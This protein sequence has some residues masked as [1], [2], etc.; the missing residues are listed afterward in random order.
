MADGSADRRFMQAALAL[1]RRGLGNVWPNPAVGC[2][3]VKDGIV[4]GRGWTQPG[5]RPHAETEALAR[6]GDAARGATAYVSLEPCSHTGQTA[7]CADALAA[8]GV[9]RVVAAMIDPD[10]R[11]SGAGLARMQEAGISVESGLLADEAAAVN[12]GFL[13]RIEQ[14]RPMVTLKL[15]ATLDGRIAAHNGD[16]QWITEEDA[17]AFAHGL[18]ASHDAVAVGSGTA[19][20]DDPHLTCRLPGLPLRPPVRIVF[21]SRLQL[22]LTRQLIATARTIPTWIVTLAETVEES[23]I[24]RAEALREL[25]VELIATSA[26]GNGRISVA[27]ALQALGE[28]GLTRL[29]VEGGGKLAASF[30]A[31]GLVDE[32]A[33]FRGPS[34][35]G[36]DGIPAIAGLGLDRVA[37]APRF[38]L[39]DSRRLGVDTFDAY[40]RV[41]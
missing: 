4:V 5:G 33:L 8:A 29:M 35:I 14:G 2:I 26:G 37:D 13:T 19:A 1:A 38:K 6:A 10:V 11:V 7:P 3:I 31:E 24:E 9:A 22:S 27:E 30:L 36:G 21:D 39:T 32:L 20:T 28:A 17:R 15:A 16:S 25:G 34:I 12:R 23:A 18:R 41:D 40:S